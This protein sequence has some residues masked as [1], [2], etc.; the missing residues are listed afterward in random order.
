MKCVQ[1]L[2]LLN[3]YLLLEKLYFSKE[4]KDDR[5]IILC[6]TETQQD[7]NTGIP[8]IQSTS[9]LMGTNKEE[10]GNQVEVNQEE[11]NQVEENQEELKYYEINADAKKLHEDSKLEKFISSSFT[12]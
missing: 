10:E 6:N 5:S 9:E 2:N 3:H 7:Y 11:A 8:S 4:M 1:N 12:I